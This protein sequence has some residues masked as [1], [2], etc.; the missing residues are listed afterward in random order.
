MENGNTDQEAEEDSEASFRLDGID[1]ERR[2]GAHDQPMGSRIGNVDRGMGNENI[3]SRIRNSNG[4]WEEVWGPEER[5]PECCPGDDSLSTFLGLQ[6]NPVLL[7]A[8][9]EGLS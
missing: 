3:E 7:H 4:Q 5:G 8:P 2:S 1:S 6:R 9:I